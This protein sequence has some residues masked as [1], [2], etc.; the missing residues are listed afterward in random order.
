MKKIIRLL[1]F[2]LACMALFAGC[3]NTNKKENKDNS[4]KQEQQDKGKKETTK[5]E[6][7]DEEGGAGKGKALLPS[8]DFEKALVSNKNKNSF[9]STVPLVGDR[10]IRSYT[11]DQQLQQELENRD[12][13]LDAPLTVLNPFGNSPLTA[14][15]LFKTEKDYAVRVTVQGNSDETDVVGLVNAGTLHRIPVIGLYPDKLNDVTIE[16]LDDDKNVVK[17]S[18]IQI[19]TEALP[20]KLVDIV[21]VEK[22]SAPSAY[23]LIEASGFG[24]P[25]PFAFDTEGNVRWYLNETYA[26]YGYFPLSNGHFIVMDKEVMIPTYSKPHAQQLYEMD[27]IGRVH[28]IYFVENGAHHEIIEKTPGGNLLVLSNSIDE[29][30]EDTVQE[31]D[32]ETGEIIKTLDMREIFGTTYVDMEDWAHLNTASYNEKDDTVVLSPRNVHSGIKVNWSTNELVWILANPEF[33]KGTPYED[34]VLQPVGDIIWHYQP[35]SIYELPYDLDNNPETIHVMLYD[36]HWHKTRKVDFF[37]DLE[38]SYVSLFTINEKEMTVSQEHIYEGLKSKITSNF[39]YNH[40]AGRVFA[41]GMYLAE[42]TEDGRNAMIYEYDYDTEEVLNQY[43]LKHTAYR[44]YEFEPDFNTCAVS[45]QLSDNY[46]KGTLRA[47][48]LNQDAE[49]APEQI[50]EEGVELSISQQLLYIKT[51]DHKV[52]HIEFIGTKNNYMLDMSYTKDGEKSY[53]KLT[54][55][56]V[57]PFSNLEPD[58]Y[59]IVLTYDGTRYNTGETITITP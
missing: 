41:M 10:V 54:Y 19:Q 53:H 20:K 30:V 35:H 52:S 11:I 40:E 1:L 23:G 25:Y 59:Q 24:T 38:P 14:V 32:R 15:V 36:N 39:R 22:S 57:I 26:S 45:M 50:L 33:W 27:Y 47:A 9:T 4:S 46:F 51:G 13:T 17:Q 29:H 18:T 34:K 42:E 21:K 37:D 31:I 55:N 16:L 43:S 8:P 12:Y 49:P 2:T 6:E 56:L 3:K 28:Q 44:G 7:E 58:E 5:E 48:S